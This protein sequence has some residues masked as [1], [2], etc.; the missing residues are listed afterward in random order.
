MS[1]QTSIIQVQ[2]A[3]Y[4]RL[5]P[6][7]I[8]ET[9]LASLG[10]VGVYDKRAVPQNAAFPYVTVGDA[11]ELPDN[12][13]GRKGYRTAHTIHIW[14]RERGTEEAASIADRLNQLLDQQ[15]LTLASHAHVYTMYDR[16]FYL[17]DPDGLTLHVAV[18][19]YIK[20]EEA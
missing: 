10:V 20:T 5:A 19:Y 16:S 15:P 1:A 2:Q 18:R 17:D 12:T 6:S 4:T 3:I 13:L 9:E 11:Y 8:P 14:S 7:D